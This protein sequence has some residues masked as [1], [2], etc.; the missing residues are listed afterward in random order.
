M[1][2]RSGILSSEDRTSTLQAELT[3]ARARLHGI[4]DA[5]KQIQSDSKLLSNRIQ[6]LRNEEQK[7]IKNIALNRAKANHLAAVR[8]GSDLRDS[9]EL[10]PDVP[11][12]AT[13][14]RARQFDDRRKQVEMGKVRCANEVKAGMHLRVAQKLAQEE[15]ERMRIQER[16]EAIKND[17]IEARRRTEIAKQEKLRSLHIEYMSRLEKEEAGRLKAEEVLET[18]KRKELELIARLER[19][20]E[21]QVVSARA[22]RQKPPTLS[23]RDLGSR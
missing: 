18:L 12:V 2:M 5:R 6:L 3:N 23:R 19:V 13:R 15:A 22:T 4:L 1:Q 8:R 7:A 14:A 11:I 9:V 16:A 17:R 21:A 10:T 20:Q